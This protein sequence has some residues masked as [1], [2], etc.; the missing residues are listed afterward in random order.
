MRELIFFENQ[1]YNCGSMS[2]MWHVVLDEVFKKIYM[3]FRLSTAAAHLQS[4]R[5][6]DTRRKDIPRLATNY[7]FPFLH[8]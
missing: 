2:Q 3:S 4:L 8:F 1:N 5:T 7:N 6:T